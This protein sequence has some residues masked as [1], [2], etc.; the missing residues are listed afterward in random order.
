M[1]RTSVLAA[2]SALALLL[3]ASSA[4]AT[5]TQPNGLIVPLDS[6]NGEVQLY[7]LFSNLGEAIDWKTDAASTPDAFSPLCAFTAKFVLKQSGASLGLG[8]YNSTNVKPSPAE[9]HTLIPAGSPVGT[10]ITSSDIKNDPAYLGGLIGFALIGGQTHYSE[11]KWDPLCSGAG[12]NPPGPWVSAVLYA[13]KNTPNA[14]YIA[15]E[16]GTMG[17]T[18]GSFNNDGDYNDDVYFLTGLTCS[19]GG[20][21]CDTK[22]LGTC[23]VGVTQCTANGTTCKG[24]VGATTETCN[25]LD[26]NC[27]GVTDEG[28]ICPTDF[29]CDKGTCVKACTTGEFACPSNQV[30][31][32]E[33]YCVDPA[34]KD[35]VCDSGTVCVAGVCQS[36]CGT[37]VC[38]YGQT[39]LGT[40]CVD[41][42]AG[43]KCDM[44]QICEKGA[45]ITACSCAPCAAGLSCDAMSGACEDPACV[46]VPC[47]AGT[48]CAAGVCVDNCAGAVCPAG[49][50]CAMGQCVAMMGTTGAGGSTGVGFGVGGG[51]GAIGAGGASGVTGGTGSTTTSGAGGGGGT[52]NGASGGCGCS[53]IGE[54]GSTGGLALCG[55]MLAAA[56]MRRRST[57]KR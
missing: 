40:G 14:F 11:S 44:G 47:G 6:M 51:G 49:Q 12:C 5:V 56:R 9:I 55:L 3:A 15:F 27:D 38:P 31:N 4:R 41:P 25:G 45:C 2:A 48:H 42:C 57:K 36:P 46:G 20:Q 19:G 52:G 53:V 24:L 39:C 35:K 22:L 29:V 8:W 26:D 50:E 33:G 37:A 43:V 13:S 34:C 16:D 32:A 30:C 1:R 23:S 28:A 10:T 54:T 21:P 18:G 7:T 17:S